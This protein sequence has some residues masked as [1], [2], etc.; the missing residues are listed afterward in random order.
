MG[1]LTGLLGLPLAPVR[2][3]IAVADQVLKQAEE[4][5]YD[6]AR[7]RQQLE[8]VDRQREAGAITEDEAIAWE[9]E[10]VDRLMNR[11]A[12]LERE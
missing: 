3:T 11:P 12:R 5:Y 4:E 7:I 1:L 8:E 10:L 6:P 2:G 9:D